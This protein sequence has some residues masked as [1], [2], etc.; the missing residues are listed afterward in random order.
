MLINTGGGVASGDRFATDVEVGPGARLVLTNVAAEKV[1]RSEGAVATVTTR[2]RVAEGG[3]L[4]WLPQETILFDRSRL[5]RHLEVD[6]AA[7]GSAILFDAVVFGRAARGEIVT[8]GYL[9]DRWRIRRAGRLVYADT[10]RLSGDIAARLS[11]PAVAAGGRAFATCLVLAPNAEDRL[12]AAREALAGL[13]SECG[14]SGR[15]GLLAARFLAQ[16]VNT[17]RQDAARFLSAMRG[18]ALPRVWNL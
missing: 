10:L 14:A 4:E 2:I 13:D 16:D 8:E 6:V 5:R 9:E 1:Y 7:G 3:L 11:H 18:R 12:D 17:L 15:D